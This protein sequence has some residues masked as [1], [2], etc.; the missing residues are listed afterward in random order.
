M[1]PKEIVPKYLKMLSD[2]FIATIAV[3]DTVKMPYLPN[4]KMTVSCLIRCGIRWKSETAMAI[5]RIL[6]EE[7]ALA[8]VSYYGLNLQSVPEEYKTAE[9]CLQAV[10]QDGLALKYVPWGQLKLTVPA[11]AELCLEAVKQNGGAFNTFQHVPGPLYKEVRARYESAGEAG[12]E[13][14]AKPQFNVP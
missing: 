5:P 8:Y 12:E 10:R 7:E 14:A 9:V 3:Y 4:S 6:S 2:T 13:P 11:M 1:L